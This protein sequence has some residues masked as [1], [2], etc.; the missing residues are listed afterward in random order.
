MTSIGN[1]APVAQWIGRR[2]PKAETAGPNPAG[3]T[4]GGRAVFSSLSFRA[5][6][7]FL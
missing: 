3:G 1:Q 7:S 4:G 5:A 6:G 2:P